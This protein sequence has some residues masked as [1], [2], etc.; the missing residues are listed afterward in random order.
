MLYI[1]CYMLKNNNN[2]IFF[3]HCKM[4]RIQIKLICIQFSICFLKNIKR[5]INVI[6]QIL[7]VMQNVYVTFRIYMHIFNF[8]S[9]TEQIEKTEQIEISI[10]IYSIDF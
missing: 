6:K 4:I 9:L 3:Q 5:S 7:K 8:N 2:F 1:I 10:S